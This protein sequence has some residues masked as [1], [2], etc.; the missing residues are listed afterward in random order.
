MINL[1]SDEN[2]MFKNKDNVLSLIIAKLK[3][4]HNII[5]K[6]SYFK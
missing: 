3:K 5:M 4:L 6:I 2:D 1:L